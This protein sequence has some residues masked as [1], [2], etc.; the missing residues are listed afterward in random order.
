MTDN[1]KISSTSARSADVEDIWLS[2]PDDPESALT[3]RIL[4]VEIVDNSKNPEAGVKACLMHQRRPSAKEPWVDADSFNLARLKGGEEVRL[5]LGAGETLDLYRQ[6]GRLHAIA[7]RGIPWGEETLVVGREDE[8]VVVG[9]QPRRIIQ[10]LLEGGD[11]EVWNALAELQPDLFRAVLVMKLHEVREGAVH[12]FAGELERDEWSEDQ[13]Q[14]FFED[15]TWIFGYGLSY[16]FLTS[17]EDQPHYGGT[18]VTGKGAQRGDFLAATEAE[19][20]FTVLVE[21]KTPSAP[22]V[23]KAYRNQAHLIGGHVAGGVTQLQTNCRTWEISGSR[24]PENQEALDSFT[25]QPKGILVIGNTSQ[26]DTLGKR[27]S[28][29]LFR[30][31]L[32]NP[33]ILTFD[34]LLERS[35]HLLLNEKRRIEVEKTGV[36]DDD[37]PF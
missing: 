2:K 15:N 9:G 37:W 33:E 27:N 3:R 5:Q 31:N 1:Y 35:R 36:D 8:T 13:W 12:V 17:V 30:R 6:L 4:R 21:I 23:G 34:E 22:L 16:R 24:E 11:E 20:R 29:E 26:L 28:F 10:E 32:N 19:R 14:E 18:N 25:V 7:E